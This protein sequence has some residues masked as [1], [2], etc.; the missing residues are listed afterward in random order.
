MSKRH[1]E[2]VSEQSPGQSGKQEISDAAKRLQR[3]HRSRSTFRAAMA[4][5]RVT[6]PGAVVALLVILAIIGP[7]IVP[8]DPLRTNSA[9]ML[10]GPTSE[11]WFGTDDRG[12]DLLS[13][14]IVGT[15]T[16]MIV[17]I[18]SVFLA[19]VI[20]V[21]FGLVGGY[22]TGIW[23]FVTMRTVDVLL[24]F[25]P[26]L[27][28]IVVVAFLGPSMI[29]LIGVIAVLYMTR[30]A[31][32][33]HGSVVQVKRREYVEGARVVGA[34]NTRILLRYI[35]PN[36]TAPIFVQVSLTVGFAILLE[37]GLSFLGLG[38]PPPAPSW[39]NMISAARSVSYMQD[40]P[41]FIIWPSVMISIAILA[42]NTLGD[43]LR[44]SLDPR[45]RQ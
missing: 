22:F 21:A 10:S 36:I 20:G 28:A 19:T 4:N 5:P 6:I 35:L 14:V 25:P 30:F 1:A 23:E 40:N 13:R 33:A 16:S 37:S 2:P 7:A 3:Q 24:T 15:R 39:G 17:A 9:N 31:R 38:T 45:L 29:N 26:I 18:A 41:S 12:R 8:H 42:F 43:G 27:L 44:D 11:H 32:I 34:G